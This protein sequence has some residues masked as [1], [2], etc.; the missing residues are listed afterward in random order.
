L[1]NEAKTNDLLRIEGPLGSFFFRK[2]T[3]TN[4]IFLATG[5]GIAPVK[6]MLENLDKN[7]TDVFG[8]TIYL[9]FGGRI[10]EDLFWK[11][12]FK[13]IQVHY[14][15]VLSR[16]SANWN[17]ATGYIQNAIMQNDIELAESVIYACG[18]ENMIQDAFDLT[19]VNGLSEDAFFSDAFISTK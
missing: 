14:I 15:P 5:T 1:F 19:R 16:S 17:G 10:Q 2:T 7:H 6:A 11:P 13:N 18:S 4:I 12:N 9:F 8:K 3:K